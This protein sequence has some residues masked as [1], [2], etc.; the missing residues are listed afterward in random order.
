MWPKVY[1]GEERFAKFGLRCLWT[2]LKGIPDRIYK[3]KKNWGKPKGTPE[4]I[5]ERIPARTAESCH[6]RISAR[7]SEDITGTLI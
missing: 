5:S 7:V 1:E 3:K 6:A 4:G 2:A